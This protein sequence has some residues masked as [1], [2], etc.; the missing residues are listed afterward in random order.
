MRGQ[1][2]DAAK[3]ARIIRAA[4][5]VE[6]LDTIIANGKVVSVF[7]G[8]MIECDVGIKD[9]VIATLDAKGLGSAETVDVRGMFVAPSFIDGHIHIESSMLCPERFAEAVVPRG[10]GAVVSDPHEI[11]NVLGV[12]GVLYMERASKSL[13]MDFYFTLPSCVPATSLETSGASIS[14]CD[15]RKLMELLPGSP[16]LSEMMNFPGVLFCDGEVLEK[17]A[18]AKAGGLKIDGHAPMLSGRALDA[19]LSAGISTDHESTTKEEV[20]EKLRKGCFILAREGSASKNLEETLKALDRFS[21]GRAAIVSDD[22]HPGSLLEEGHLDASLRKAVKAGLDPVEALRLVTINPALAFGLSGKGAVAPGYY[23]DLAILEDLAS[24]KAISVFHK[25]RLA[26]RD[27][28]LMRELS[29]LEEKSVLSSV[30]LPA[31]LEAKLVYPEKGSV[32]VIKVFPEQILTKKETARVSDAACGAINLAAVI[33]RHGK[34]G[35]VGVGFVSG[36]N[37]KAGAIASTVSH[38][39]HN[40][41]AVG[42]SAG[43]IAFAARSVAEIGGGYVVVKNGE[44]LA[45]LPLEVA[46]LMSREPAAKVASALKDLHEKAASL[47]TTLPSP[48]MTMSFIALPVIPELRLTDKGL[49]DVG[50]FD[51]VPLKAE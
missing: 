2:E 25:G 34:N 32:R 37:L 35:N 36:F 44:V 38:D 13:P 46:G 7:T 21:L 10:T 33:E 16:A 27:G 48:L 31:D 14:S 12:P 20:L 18:A 24:F 29:V 17:I 1:K 15:I 43:E 50:K 11:A 51:F 28:K 42:T 9:G 22:R 47:G 39:S 49:V 19:Y 23:A 40:I 26:A 4:R 6:P 3:T 45:R 8:E 5:G 41:V 30:T